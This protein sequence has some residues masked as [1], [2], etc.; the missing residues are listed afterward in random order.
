MDLFRLLRNSE[1]CG[2]PNRMSIYSSTGNVTI[3]P[4][5]VPQNT[6][7]PGKWEY[8]GCL[9]YVYQRLITFN[10]LTRLELVNPAR[11]VFS[12]TS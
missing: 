6:S 9:A 2:G 8:Q 4:V 11:L 7:L 5:P 3:L 10:K 12:L 1:A